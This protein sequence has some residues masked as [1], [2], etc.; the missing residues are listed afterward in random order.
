MPYCND[1]I[2][3]KIVRH[4]AFK[5]IF[6]AF[7]LLN[8]LLSVH[9]LRSYAKKKGFMLKMTRIKEKNSSR[10]IHSSDKLR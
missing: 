10:K 9:I 8:L 6:N 4:R 1:I 5:I 7:F 2:I 3:C